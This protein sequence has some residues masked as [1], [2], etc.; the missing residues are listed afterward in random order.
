LTGSSPVLKTMGIVLVA[1][2]CR[3]PAGVVAAI[4]LT[5]RGRLVDRADAKIKGGPL[6]RWLSRAFGRRHGRVSALGRSRKPLRVGIW[7]GLPGATLERP[8]DG[9]GGYGTCRHGP[10]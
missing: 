10:N 8:V 1:D 7:P 5:P 2:F 4:T 9:G 6:H 3:N